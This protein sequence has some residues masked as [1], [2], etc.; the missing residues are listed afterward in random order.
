MTG[1]TAD[2][3]VAS[4]TVLVNP[5]GQYG[6]YPASREIPTGWQPAGFTGTEDECVAF[7]DEHWTDLRP[8]SLRRSMADTGRDGTS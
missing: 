2:H 6:I 3:A 8:A 5:E 4:S 1:D 7:V